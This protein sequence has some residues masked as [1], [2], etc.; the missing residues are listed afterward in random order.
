MS[1]HVIFLVNPFWHV[2]A[3]DRCKQQG[4][5][6]QG[7]HVHHYWKHHHPQQL[8]HNV[9]QSQQPQHGPKLGERSARFI[10]VMGKA[11]CPAYA[12]R[13]QGQARAAGF[14]HRHGNLTCHI[15]AQNTYNR[16]A[17]LES[18]DIS[19]KECIE[20]SNVRNCYH[21]QVW[22]DTSLPQSHP[23]ERILGI[24]EILPPSFTTSMKSYR[25]KAFHHNDD[26]DDMLLHQSSN[27][28]PH[29][30]PWGLLSMAVNDDNLLLLY[31]KDYGKLGRFRKCM[32]VATHHRL[33]NCDGIMTIH[34]IF[35]Y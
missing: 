5:Q 32:S 1:G 12:G 34:S 7:H 15:N 10:V 23:D 14:Y 18:N 9:E 6:Y 27:C 8:T 24:F 17:P 3:T 19:D 16:C 35:I 21:P 25:V 31:A 29:R 33:H 26:G 20:L 11:K 30:T 2:T 13:Q 22:P 28:H 4:R